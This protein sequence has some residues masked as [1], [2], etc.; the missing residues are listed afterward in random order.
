MLFEGIFDL[1]SRINFGAKSDQ[2]WIVSFK[3]DHAFNE[4]FAKTLYLLTQSSCGMWLARRDSN[5]SHWL[6]SH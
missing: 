1:I 5:L 6:V 3:L 2:N 4:L